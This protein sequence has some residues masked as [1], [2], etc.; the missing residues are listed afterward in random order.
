[1]R[2]VAVVSAV[3]TAVGKAKK[4]TLKDTRPDD[5]LGAVMK[6]AVERGGIDPAEVR[7]IVVGTAMPEAEQGMKRR[8]EALI[9]DLLGEAGAAAAVAAAGD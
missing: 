6:A 7:D 2:E 1:M 5:L 3:R 4:G 9:E 8:F